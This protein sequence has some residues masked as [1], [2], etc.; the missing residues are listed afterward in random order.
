MQPLTAQDFGHNSPVFNYLRGIPP[1]LLK[2]NIL[3]TWGEGGT[4]NSAQAFE[5]IVAEVEVT[6]Q[7]PSATHVTHSS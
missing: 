7:F 2:T 6:V 5:P 4:G 3:R 1:I